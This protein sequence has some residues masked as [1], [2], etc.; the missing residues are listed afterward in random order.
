V[1]KFQGQEA[2]VK[3]SGTVNGNQMK[4]AAEIP[5]NGGTKIEYAVKKVE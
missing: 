4:L 2:K 5:M 1:L 3:Y